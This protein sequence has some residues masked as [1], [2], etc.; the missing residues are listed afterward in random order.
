MNKAEKVTKIYVRSDCTFAHS[1]KELRQE[2]QRAEVS[3]T[4]QS[5]WLQNGMQLSAETDSFSI[6]M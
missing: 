3:K 2:G 4:P 1:P 5:P 6:R